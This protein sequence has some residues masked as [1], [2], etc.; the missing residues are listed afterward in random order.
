[1]KAS[2]KVT[3]IFDDPNLIGAAGLVPAMLLAEAAGLHDL[4]AERLDVA[5]PNV[6]AKTGS[7]VAGMLA[8]ADSIDDL[9]V[10]RHGGMDRVFTD[11]RAP[12]TLG[13]HLRA[14]TQGQIAQLD[15]VASRFLAGLVAR[16]PGLIAGAADSDGIAFVDVDDTIR[17]VHGYAKQGAAYG[18]SKVKG[19][20]AQLAVVSTPL[21]APV[22]AAATLR[23]GN[24]ASAKGSG[25]LLARALSTARSAGV[26]SRVLV[27]AD[28][29]YYTHSF[30]AAALRGEVWFSVTARRNKQVTA[31]IT[32]I[33]EAAWTPIKYPNAVWEEDECPGMGRWVSEAEVAEIDFV[34]FTSKKKREQVGC[35]L[36]VRRVKRL[37]PVGGG[38]EQGELFDAYRHH[39]FVT[40]S[41]L[42]TVEAD[43]RHRDHAV[44]EQ[45]IAEL[46]DGP[47]AHLPS[48]KKTANS[49]WLAHTVMA[50]NLARA[51]GV[52]A[53]N[54]HARARWATLR[55][56]LINIP[57]RIA[58]SGG[59]I[60]LH[61]ARDWP[62]AGAWEQLF[63]GAAD[64]PL[65]AA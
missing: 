19:L 37:N 54:R 36:V 15:A 32:R 11:L 6:V 48:G 5:S 13:T 42:G 35:R 30:I 29:A 50:F 34:A 44:I 12:S 23:K 3:P 45:V 22:I 59:A 20:N 53:G 61:L 49:A 39:A 21:A 33:P 64:T 24:T 57:G 52:L 14:F 63:D 41:T 26:R 40:N 51:A 46:K 18:Y 1:M 7:I 28:S 62:W 4:A 9:D 17:Q 38:T 56:H 65:A 16:V 31:A 47:M 43:A 27:R 58:T 2:H 55:T 25:R 60:K 8:G 10:L